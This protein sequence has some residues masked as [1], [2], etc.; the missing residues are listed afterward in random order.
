[1][2]GSARWRARANY[3][4]LA[5]DLLFFFINAAF[6]LFKAEKIVLNNRLIDYHARQHL[7]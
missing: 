6:F 7:D 2:I 3:P 5:P 1:L 4:E